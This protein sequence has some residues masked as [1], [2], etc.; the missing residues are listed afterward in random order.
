MSTTMELSRSAHSFSSSTQSKRF[1]VPRSSSQIKSALFRPNLGEGTGA[2]DLAQHQESQ[3]YKTHVRLSLAHTQS[4]TCVANQYL[5]IHTNKETQLLLRLGQSGDFQKSV[6]MTTALNLAVSV[7][8]TLLAEEKLELTRLRESQLM[9]RTL[10]DTIEETRLHI[11][12]A[13]RQ[14]GTILDHAGNTTFS[15]VCEPEP[16]Y[17]N[18]AYQPIASSTISAY[19]QH[20]ENYLKTACP[21]GDGLN[22]A[23]SC[24][25]VSGTGS[26][27]TANYGQDVIDQWSYAHDS[28]V[29]LG[30]T[31]VSTYD[32]GD[33]D[34]LPSD[35]SALAATAQQSYAY[36]GAVSLGSNYGL[37]YGQ[38]GGGFV[39]SAGS[40]LAATAEQSYAY[41]DAVSLGGNYGPSHGQDGGGFV[42]SDGSALAA[43]VQQ[44]YAYD[45]A[46]S[47]RTDY[48]ATYGQDA[49]G[50]W[51]KKA[52]VDHNFVPSAGSALAATTQQPPTT[53]LNDE[54][55]N[56]SEADKAAV[57]EAHFT[58]SS[59]N[60]HSNNATVVPRG[61]Y[62]DPSFF[63]AALAGAVEEYDLNPT[64]YGIAAVRD[65]Q[66][67]DHSFSY[68]SQ[69][70]AVSIDERLASQ[71][72]PI[73]DTAAV[74]GSRS[75]NS[76]LVYSNPV[77]GH[78]L[79]VA[80]LDYNLAAI[81]GIPS[82][83]FPLNYNELAVAMDGAN[84]EPEN[85]PDCEPDDGSDNDYEADDGTNDGQGDYYDSFGHV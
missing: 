28:A 73:Y 72:F 8:N 15:T 74:P 21:F 56:L 54:W 37:S 53:V 49:I 52:P 50:K 24:P 43:T 61:Q 6:D 31:A 81:P 55:S 23:A 19:R 1:P 14:L 39:P 69:S 71:Y 36:E 30:S 33:G 82:S 5:A 51:L 47:T 67:L 22:Q 77:E 75:S 16:I 17:H 57:T 11:E 32:Q 63:H 35:G 62:L 3:H 65:G 78:G 38:D 60:Y 42:P 59:Q 79:Q 18:P 85:E 29:S 9:T 20:L 25:T 7:R 58:S 41:D 66:P 80:Y 2:V 64:Q 34:L 48:G 12:E 68:T 40:A 27:Y 4:L 26:D 44:P 13:E 10:Q 45:A 70:Q 83:D 76:S 46:I 84:D